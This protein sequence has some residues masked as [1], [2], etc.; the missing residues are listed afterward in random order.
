M[1]TILNTILN[2]EY[3]ETGKLG[4][5]SSQLIPP[6]KNDD[7]DASIGGKGKE[8]EIIPFKRNYNRWYTIIHPLLDET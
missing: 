1:N 2:T 8:E 5:K 3:V 6:Q 4:R 7:V